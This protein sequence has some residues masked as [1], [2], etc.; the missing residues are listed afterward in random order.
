LKF[1]QTKVERQARV[2]ISF[3]GLV[4]ALTCSVIFCL[5]ISGCD[6]K[7][8]QRLGE[9]VTKTV[10]ASDAAIEQ[11]GN[12]D[13]DQAKKEF[14]KLTQYEYQVKTFRVD[15][16]AA[17]LQGALSVMGHDGW[18]CGSPLLRKEDI[19]LTC[20]KR[21]ESLLRYVPQSLLSKP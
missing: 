9:F 20:K 18:D 4:P 19:L 11:L 6:S 15:I 8:S 7:D 10:D 17:E 21:P 14:K 16:P 5:A 2:K 1:K 13:S 12:L 3:F